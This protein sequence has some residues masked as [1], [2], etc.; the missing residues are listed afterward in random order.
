MKA[1][2]ELLKKLEIPTDNSDF[3]YLK[4]MLKN[5]SGYMYMFTKFRF[6]DK[7]SMSRLKDLFETLKSAK[8]Y[9]KNLPKPAA[10]YRNITMLEDDL[11]IAK[12]QQNV[13]NFIN[14]CPSKLKNDFKKH[15]NDLSNVFKRACNSFAQLN[16]IQQHLFTKTLS[17]YKTV[18][19]A[20]NALR[21]FIDYTEVGSDMYSIIEQVKKENYAYIRHV[22]F[23][24]NYLVVRTSEKQAMHILGLGT[25][26]C[27]A[28]PNMHYWSNYINDK[29]RHQQYIIYDFNMSYMHPMHRIGVTVRDNVIT[30]CHRFGNEALDIHNLPDY[31]DIDVFFNNSN[32]VILENQFDKIATSNRYSVQSIINALKTEKYDL[33]HLIFK[34][35]VGIVKFVKVFSEVINRA[36]ENISA[37]YYNSFIV[38]LHKKIGSTKYFDKFIPSLHLLNK[39]SA[40]K[41]LKDGLFIKYTSHLT[42][43]LETF[44]VGNKTTTEFSQVVIDGVKYIKEVKLTPLYSM[45]LGALDVILSTNEKIVTNKHLM[46]ANN[47]DDIELFK[48]LLKN[49]NGTVRSLN[50]YKPEFRDYIDSVSK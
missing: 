36:S 29:I 43:I 25:Q 40:Q 4:D 35:N 48:I 32:A 16:K 19:H 49:F 47:V 38:N 10:N 26:W 11:E 3:L 33:N 5:N 37:E 44:F 2:K 45:D 50:K 22:D 20:S 28:D 8:P 12:I 1:S 13:I 31:I 34:E 41:M 15:I 42:Q 17:R 21:T 30:N 14:L 9:I 7:I 6:E 27:I 24:N 39:D 18:T 46:H 23:E